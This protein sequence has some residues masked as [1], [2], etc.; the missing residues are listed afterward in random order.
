LFVAIFYGDGQSLAKLVASPRPAMADGVK[1]G[2]GKH[3]GSLKA[4]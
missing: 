4:L 3:E 1:L 2:I